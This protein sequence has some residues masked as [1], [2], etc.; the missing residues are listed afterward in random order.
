MRSSIKKRLAALETVS[1]SDEPADQALIEEQIQ[2]AEYMA[3]VLMSFMNQASPEEAERYMISRGIPADE[4]RHL[5][6]LG[7]SGA[8]DYLRSKEG[9]WV[10]RQESARVR[11]IAMQQH[12]PEGKR[13]F[14]VREPG[15]VR[16]SQA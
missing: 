13:I 4:A 16:G 12:H 2:R 11:E 14:E 15:K 3:K 1:P 9:A 8:Q 6:K 7:Y 10:L 5:S